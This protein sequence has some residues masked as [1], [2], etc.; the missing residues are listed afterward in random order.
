M[1]RLLVSIEF[2]FHRTDIH[3][4]SVWLRRSFKQ[5]SQGA[6]DDERCQGID[7]KT[8]A[9]SGVWISP[10]FNSQLLLLR[11]SNC[12]PCTSRCPEGSVIATSSDL[13]LSSLKTASW[14]KAA[15]SCEGRPWRPGVVDVSEF[16]IAYL[17]P[18]SP[19]TKWYQM[20]NICCGSSNCL[21]SSVNNH[22]Q[23]WLL[24]T[25]FIAHRFNTSEETKICTN[26]LQLIYPLRGIFRN[27]PQPNNNV[28]HL[29]E[30]V[31]WWERA[32]PFAKTS[33]QLEN[34]SSPWLR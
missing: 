4:I 10:N 20:C 7:T 13:I 32:L 8:Y 1:S 29:E 33:W 6:I 25:K 12:C 14:D 28:V 23:I 11:R 30:S 17:D 15:L 31:W 16:V 34:L 26:R 5:R 21:A 3:N 18:T 2:P 22:I 27:L 9:A 24:L 19:S